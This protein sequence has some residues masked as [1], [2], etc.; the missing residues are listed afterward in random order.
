[1]CVRVGLVCVRVGLVC[2]GRVRCEG[3]A[4]K[5]RGVPL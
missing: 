2:E 3:R 4:G 5:E 1:M